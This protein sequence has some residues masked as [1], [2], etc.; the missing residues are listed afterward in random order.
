MIYTHLTILRFVIRV[1]DE[2]LDDA[3]VDQ[4]NVVDT[5][6]INEAADCMRALR[7]GSALEKLL[8]DH[9]RSM[10]NSSDCLESC[11]FPIGRKTDHVKCNEV[12]IHRGHGW[13]TYVES[14]E[15]CK[16]AGYVSS[17]MHMRELQLY[18]RNN[19]CMVELGIRGADV[20]GVRNIGMVFELETN[21]GRYSGQWNEKRACGLGLLILFNGVVESGL[22]KD[23][24]L[25]KGSI[26]CSCG[27]RTVGRFTNGWITDGKTTT[28]DG[29]VFRGVW[30]KDGLFKKGSKTMDDKVYDG[31]WKDN[32]MKKGTCVHLNGDVYTGQFEGG[33]YNGIGTLRYMNNGHFKEYDGGWRDGL[34]HG[35]GSLFLSSGG[36][37]FDGLF[38]YGSIKKCIVS[39][40][41]KSVWNVY[42]QDGQILRVAVE[43][44]SQRMRAHDL[45]ELKDK[46]RRDALV[47]HERHIVM[48]RRAALKLEKLERVVNEL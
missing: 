36:L 33:M 12:C 43:T 31:V 6:H 47:A 26:S 30:G 42:E 25:I 24:R 27:R 21:I 38:E 35:K 18:F 45:A 32:H 4:P 29:D 17:Q 37:R 9:R 39:I 11:C 22:W 8:E 5:A 28:I 34:Y 2:S 1:S 41:N 40:D 3:S 7:K 48:E 15:I 19:P 10:E 14:T 16:A 23:G 46:E 44:N 13:T 20:V